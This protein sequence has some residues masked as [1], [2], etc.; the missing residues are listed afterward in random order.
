V[1]RFAPRADGADTTVT[2]GQAPWAWQSGT[3]A[4]G[5]RYNISDLPRIT[6][7][8][9]DVEIENLV[10]WNTNF[11]CV[12]EITTE[13]DK[14]VFKLQQPYGAIAQQVGWSAGL[15]MDSTHVI[16]NAF[17]L[18]HAPGEF[19]FDR[20]RR[21]VYYI[22]RPGEDMRTARVMVPV[23]QTLIRLS[24]KS[25][26]HRVRNLTFE[27]LTF[28]CTDYN[29]LDVAGSH[30]VSTLQTACVYTAFANPNWHLDVYR[31]FDVL[32]GCDRSQR[33]RGRRV[34]PQYHHAHRLRGAGD[35]QRHQRY[36]RGGECHPRCRRV[37]HLPGSPAACLRE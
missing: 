24:G 31:A 28:T 10:T 16:Q 4:D 14:Y 5:I 36:P 30:G 1:G 13:G 9:T 20:A 37:R 3:A 8:P 11:V 35:D 12:R 17:E 15:T 21:T 22:P 19:Y 33:H 32:P 2:A 6:R 29:L 27:G 7:N 26:K 18:L 23:T 25:L 34:Y